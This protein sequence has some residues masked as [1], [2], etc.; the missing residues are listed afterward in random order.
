MLEMSWYGDT[1]VS[2]GLGGSFHTKRL[3]LQASQV[4]SVATARR[5]TRTLADRLELALALL[6]D[7]AFDVLLTG[8]SAFDEL[9]D[10]LARLASGDLP[11]LCHTIRYE[12]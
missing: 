6:R 3:T 8:E 10:V 5:S 12:D 7:D 2:V 9:P 4:G 11:A 1:P